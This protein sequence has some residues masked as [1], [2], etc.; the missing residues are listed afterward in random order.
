MSV[1]DKMRSF[2]EARTEDRELLPP[3]CLSY[4]DIREILGEL[5]KERRMALEHCSKIARD[6]FDAWMSEHGADTPYDAGRC[7]A[8]DNVRS[9]I[10]ADLRSNQ[11]RPATGEHDG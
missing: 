4:G 11:R 7:T 2:S 5:A 10:N 8:L 6:L 9:A 1:I 3:A